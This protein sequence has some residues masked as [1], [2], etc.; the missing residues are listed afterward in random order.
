MPAG[1][2]GVLLRWFLLVGTPPQNSSSH[3]GRTVIISHLLPELL[4]HSWTCKRKTWE[5]QRNAALPC[6]FAVKATVSCAWSCPPF[7]HGAD[8]SEGP[9]L[10]TL[11]WLVDEVMPPGCLLCLLCVPAGVWCFLVQSF[12]C[13]RTASLSLLLLVSSFLSV[14]FVVFIGEMS[15]G[16]SQP[17]ILLTSLSSEL[18]FHCSVE[19]A[20]PSVWDT[21]GKWTSP[22][23]ELRLWVVPVLMGGR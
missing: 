7:P 16:I 20:L 19:S 15:M 5:W 8:F 3:H 12:P 18:I 6:P 11:P 2:P 10:A 1:P 23:L 17:F 21:H 13:F 22:R 4:I 14:V 9:L